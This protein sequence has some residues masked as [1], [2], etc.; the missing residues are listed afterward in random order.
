MTKTGFTKIVVMALFIFGISSSAAFAQKR[1]AEEGEKI[2]I[3]SIFQKYIVARALKDK[4]VL[5]NM[6]GYDSSQVDNF[7]DDPLWHYKNY[8][9][10]KAIVENGDGKT[11]FT[12]FYI[13]SKDGQDENFVLIVNGDYSDNT[14]TAW[15]GPWQYFP[16][17]NES[18]S[19]TM[20][21][22]EEELDKWFSIGLK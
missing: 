6:F 8:N 14:S 5:V 7:T 16:Y 17:N 2:K 12:G 15:V 4:D 13:V 3:D 21:E 20:Q 10:K 18:K 22:A 19:Y 11:K 1:E 9:L